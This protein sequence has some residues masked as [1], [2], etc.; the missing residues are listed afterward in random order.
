MKLGKRS[1]ACTILI[2]FECLLNLN[3]YELSVKQV[4]YTGDVWT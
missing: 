3:I 1:E 4:I 2:N